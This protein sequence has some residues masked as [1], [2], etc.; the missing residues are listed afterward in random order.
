MNDKKEA[1]CTMEL[2]NKLWQK[3]SAR[4]SSISPEWNVSRVPHSKQL[5]FRRGWFVRYS[6]RLDLLPIDSKREDE[7][8]D[9]LTNIICSDLLSAY[10]KL[11]YK[12][13]TFPI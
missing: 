3:V 2:Y 9:T 5:R 7:Y 1:S 10:E 11:S 12:I 13:Q 6:T 8:L 4:M